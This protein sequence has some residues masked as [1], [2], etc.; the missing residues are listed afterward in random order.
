MKKYEVKLS[1]FTKNGLPMRFENFC[2][3]ND[4]KDKECYEDDNDFNCVDED[5]A[6]GTERIMFEIKK[7]LL[8]RGVLVQGGK[9]ESFKLEGR[10]NCESEMEILIEE[11]ATKMERIKTL[12][13][14]V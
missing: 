1:V 9:L 14:E 8:A 5:G 12:K 11:V 10:V 13:R 2:I 3:V 7:F 6:G 4:C